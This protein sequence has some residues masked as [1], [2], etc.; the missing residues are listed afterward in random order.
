MDPR[1]RR[2]IVA[3]LVVAAALW[4]GSRGVDVEPASHLGLRPDAVPG[5]I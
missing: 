3:I 1:V 4:L 2:L 5:P